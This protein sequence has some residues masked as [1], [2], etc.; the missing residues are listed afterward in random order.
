MKQTDLHTCRIPAR[1]AFA[2]HMNRLVTGN[3]APSSPERAEMLA[4]ADQALDLAPFFHLPLNG[5]ALC[6]VP[7]VD[8][9]GDASAPKDSGT[10]F[11]LN[12]SDS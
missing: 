11:T 2:D 7:V 12:L 10:Y 3:C 8:S 4:C 1:L 6:F 9:V 5:A